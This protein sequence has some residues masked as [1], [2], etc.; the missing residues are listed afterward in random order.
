MKLADISS[1]PVWGIW[2]LIVLLLI[3]DITLLSGHGSWLISGYNTASKEEKAQYDEKK[4]CRVT[5][6]GMLAITMIVLVTMV[7]EN[8]LP[9]YF[10]YI[11]L[12]IAL[13]IVAVIN[14]LASTICKKK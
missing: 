6:G 10:A 11:M 8:V 4:L 14:I 1:G 5:G 9:E 7:F 12:G 3:I 13:V 2:I